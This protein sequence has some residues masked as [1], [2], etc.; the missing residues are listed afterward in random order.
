LR[1]ELELAVRAGLGGEDHPCGHAGQKLPPIDHLL[2]SLKSTS[3]TNEADHHSGGKSSVAID[4]ARFRDRGFHL[5]GLN[6]VTE[7]IGRMPSPALALRH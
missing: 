2:L 4:A 3:M 7:N 1:I 5:P 6:D